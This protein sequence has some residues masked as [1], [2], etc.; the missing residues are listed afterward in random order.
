MT[1]VIC[2][3]AEMVGPETGVTIG[4]A[5]VVGIFVI[6]VVLKVNNKI[7]HVENTLHTLSKNMRETWSRKDQKIFSLELRIKNPAMHVPHVETEE[8][9]DT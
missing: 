1:A 4:A 8:K 6:G 9:E 5:I 3:L 7:T 2:I